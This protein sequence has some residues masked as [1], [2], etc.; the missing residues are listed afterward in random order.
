MRFPLATIDGD[1]LR[2]N[3]AVVRQ[4]APDAKVIA[5]IKANAYGH[6]LLETAR[7]LASTDAFGVARLDEGLALRVASIASRIVLLEGVFTAAELQ[8]AAQAKLDL[9]VHTFEQLQL[10]ESFAA[11]G[12]F[13][14]WVKL[15]SGMNRLG[16]RAE[17]FAAAWSRLQ[18]CRCVATLRAMTHLA[19]AEDREGHA[20]REQLARFERLTGLLGVERSVANSAGLI[21]TSAARL[22]WVRP[23]L[24]LYGI[25]PVP[26]LSAAQL[27]LR[28]AM[29]LM[30]QLI[31]TRDVP[32]GEGVG[33]GAIWR[34]PVDSRIGI[35]AV[36]YGDG[37]PRNMRGG[38]PVLVGG[39]RTTVVGRVSMDMT[40]VDLTQLPQAQ[41][42]DEVTLWGE[43]LGAEEVAPFADTIAYELVCG[44]SQRV[45][46][47]WKGSVIRDS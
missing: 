6:G 19:A 43:Q 5:V 40:A 10:L 15:D 16:F 36:G 33:Y 38:T 34:A 14:V 31:A 4:L 7:A 37:Y 39:V 41:V 17:H 29:T 27:G 46:V 28:P 22:D 20:T 11:A 18:R 8:T 25:S 3:L 23:G 45:A 44:I 12:R 24:M 21:L 30:T 1:A 47:E 26:G 9:V 32:K 13:D 2:H 42:G 35:A